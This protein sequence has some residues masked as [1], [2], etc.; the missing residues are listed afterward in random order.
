MLS[1]VKFNNYLLAGCELQSYRVIAEI[2]D[3]SGDEAWEDPTMT[4]L[5]VLVKTF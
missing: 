2:V 3:D 5:E 1:L 4:D